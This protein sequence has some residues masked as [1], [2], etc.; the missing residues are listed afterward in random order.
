MAISYFDEVPHPFK[1]AKPQC[2]KVFFKSYRRLIQADKVVCPKC[3]TTIDI[4][5]SKRTGDIGSWIYTIAELQKK[6]GKKK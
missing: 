4:R 6:F 1:C 2:G 5:E 3:R